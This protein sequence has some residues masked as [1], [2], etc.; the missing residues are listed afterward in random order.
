[1]SLLYLHIYRTKFKNTIERLVAEPS[2]YSFTRLAIGSLI[3]NES[4][5]LKSH[6]I[7]CADRLIWPDS[8]GGVAGADDEL[9]C[10][11]EK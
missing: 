8:I 10:E 9:L 11:H 6:S 4:N 2:G 3:C 5:I 7:L 1:M